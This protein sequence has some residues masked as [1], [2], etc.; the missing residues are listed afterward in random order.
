MTLYELTKK[1]SSGNGEDMMW[2]TVRIVSDA[3]ESSMDEHAKNAL[4]RK[5]FGAMSDKHYNE[6]LAKADVAKMYYTDA[7]GEKHQATYWPEEAVKPIYENIREEIPDYNF[8][9][10]Y[11][12]MNMRKSDEW[13]T[14][15]R[16]F[17]NYN[18]A[19]LDEKVTELA[20]SWLKDEDWPTKTKIWDYL[21]AR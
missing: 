12:V 15:K 10:F 11:V 1:Y 4:M 13:E 19:E 20:V 3:V 6:E 16:W 7:D 5:V 9:D 17:P 14:L 21:S 2:K 18:N 8:W